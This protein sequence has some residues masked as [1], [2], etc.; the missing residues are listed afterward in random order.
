MKNYVRKA[1]SIS[2]L[3]FVTYWATAQRDWNQVYSKE[4]ITI[5]T[6]SKNGYTLVFIN[7]DSAFDKK[8][9]QRMVDVF[10]KVYPEEVKIY[11]PKSLKTVAIIIDPE[12]KGVA[13]AS[14]GIVRVNPDWTHKHPEDIDVV[15]HEVMHIVQSYPDRSGPGWITEGIADYVRHKLGVNNAAGGWSLPAF[16]AEQSYR[17]AYRV[18]ARFFLWIE[19]N[20]SPD[21]VIKLDSAMREKKY[22]PAFWTTETGKTVDELWARYSENPLIL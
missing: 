2:L 13:A 4:D 11:N 5:D 16:K 7:K 19:K 9:Q 14:A 12:Y 15:T 18:T 20:Y 3:V 10:F 6:I 1:V 17:N 21:L 8:V 22:T